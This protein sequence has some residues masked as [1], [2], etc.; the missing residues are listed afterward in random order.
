MKLNIYI[1]A[2]FNNH[3]NHFLKYHTP[4]VWPSVWQRQNWL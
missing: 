2:K 3:H 1:I 4:L